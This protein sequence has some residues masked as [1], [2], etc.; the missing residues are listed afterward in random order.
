MNTHLLQLH[1]DVK[2]D[3]TAA[4]DDVETKLFAPQKFADRF[5][6]LGTQ[7]QGERN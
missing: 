7:Q 3:L 1:D 6:C 2:I 4:I 5:I